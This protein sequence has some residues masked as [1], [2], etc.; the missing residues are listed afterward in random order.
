MSESPD[1]SANEPQRTRPRHFSLLRA[2][3]PA[4]FITLANASC[5]M[6]S[7]IGCLRFAQTG[8][9]GAMWAALALLPLAFVF[10]ALDGYIA[11]ATARSSAYGG[12]LDS[13]ADTVSFGVAPASVGYV[14]GLN[15]G[16][17]IL[18][19]CGF[20]ACGIGRLAR[21]NVT[22]LELT[23]TKGKVSHFEGAPIPSSLLLV[24]LLAVAFGQGAIG[25]EIWLGELRLGWVMHPLALL[26]VAFGALMVTAT[27]KIP[28]P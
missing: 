16:W 17:D 14:L 22:A 12:D 23:T 27:V 1:A 11:R 7:V 10:D 6:G 26:Y 8:E 4:D 24:G 3:A 13:L 18:C 9:S 25:D 19:L 15:G 20:V 5:G 21:F 2:L 28:K